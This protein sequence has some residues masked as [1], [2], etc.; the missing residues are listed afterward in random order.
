ME[1]LGSG[2]TGSPKP[3]FPIALLFILNVSLVHSKYVHVYRTTD[4]PPRHAVSFCMT[5]NL[6]TV[7]TK[8]V[9]ASQLLGGTSQ[10][11]KRMTSWDKDVGGLSSAGICVIH[12]PI[13]P[14]LSVG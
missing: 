9:Q 10:T 5:L 13:H 4:P 6:R 7:L 8:I 2:P 14:H 12:C 1:S 3:S 11:P